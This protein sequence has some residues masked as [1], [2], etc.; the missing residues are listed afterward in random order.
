MVKGR[1]VVAWI[2]RSEIE[3]RR[4]GIEVP[5][6]RSTQSG[7]QTSAIAALAATIT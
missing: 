7:L 1:K 4:D 6:F 3:D 5:G 2:E